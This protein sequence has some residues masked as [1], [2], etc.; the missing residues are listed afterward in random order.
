M[1]TTH[2]AIPLRA[3]PPVPEEPLSL[4]EYLATSY[5]PDCDFVDGH[6]EERTVGET[7]HGLLQMQIGFW[8]ISRRAE[9][10]VRVIS[11]LRTRT[12]P[13]R[14]RIPDI[15]VVREDHAL[16][17]QVRITPAPIAIEILSPEDRLNRMIIRLQ[18]F[19]AMGVPNV[20][21]RD[22]VERVAYTLTS[23]GLKL[24]DGPRLIVAES[25][26]YLDLPEIFAAL[27]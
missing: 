22:P 18:E 25:P 11:E 4:E 26:I 8:F 10:G 14:I 23:D 15:S 20:W 2:S 6:I 12:D 5:H 24:A 17:E 1:A 16:R 9:W 13:A 21:L 7:K 19:L 3:T 27:D